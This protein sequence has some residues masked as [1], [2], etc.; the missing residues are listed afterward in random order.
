MPN[1]LPEKNS[2]DNFETRAKLLMQ[3]LELAQIK[4]GITLRPIITQYGPDLQLQDKFAK[5]ATVET[6]KPQQN[7]PIEKIK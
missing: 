7:K 2:V 5:S 4:R 3:D 1:T 6:I